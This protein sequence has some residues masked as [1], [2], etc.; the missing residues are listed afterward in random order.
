MK[1]LKNKNHL[2]FALV[3]VFSIFVALS[4]VAASDVDV[5]SENNTI[6][7]PVDNS[8]KVISD[9]NTDFTMVCKISFR[10]S[11]YVES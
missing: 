1:M 10:Y 2:I 11:F 9:N 6:S 8:H 3:A 4:C 5:M 7:E